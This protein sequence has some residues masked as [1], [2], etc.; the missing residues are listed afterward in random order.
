MK[1]Q[2]QQERDFPCFQKAQSQ[3]CQYFGANAGTKKSIGNPARQA[4]RGK[5]LEKYRIGKRRRFLTG[6]AGQKITLAL[7][8]GKNKLFAVA[9]EREQS[10]EEKSFVN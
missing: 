10:K 3:S 8:R 4:E 5:S 9:A 6:F 1:Q 2:Q 7:S